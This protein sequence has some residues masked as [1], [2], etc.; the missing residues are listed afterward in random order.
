MLFRDYLKSNGFEVMTSLPA[1]DALACIHKNAAP[2]T[3]MSVTVA[4]AERSFSKL[5]LFADLHV[6]AAFMHSGNN[7]H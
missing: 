7:F 6:A 4:S 2:F 5:K 1:R 3:T